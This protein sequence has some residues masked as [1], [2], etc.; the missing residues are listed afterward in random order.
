MMLVWESNMA[1]S[2]VA[3]A[4]GGVLGGDLM[5]AWRGVRE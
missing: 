4:D 5:L 3:I 2:Y 1:G